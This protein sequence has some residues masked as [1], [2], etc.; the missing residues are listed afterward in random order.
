MNKSSG[1]GIRRCPLVPNRVI[2]L[3]HA[4]AVPDVGPVT[5]DAITAS[6]AGVTIVSPTRII[7]IVAVASYIG[8]PVSTNLPGTQTAATMSGSVWT[9]TARCVGGKGAKRGGQPSQGS[10]P[11]PRNG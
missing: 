11:L 1:R 8:T 10:K 7:R 9:Y 2:M 3:P 5:A 4:V 6:L